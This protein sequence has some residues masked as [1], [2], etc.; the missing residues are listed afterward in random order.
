MDPTDPAE[1]RHLKELKVE[2]DRDIPATLLL[3]PPGYILGKFPAGV[4]REQLIEKL[5]SSQSCC[6]G[7]K[8]GPGG[9]CGRGPGEP[10]K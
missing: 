3:A 7:G 4:S 10:K 5:K 8:C 9:C 6:P 1:A 2:T